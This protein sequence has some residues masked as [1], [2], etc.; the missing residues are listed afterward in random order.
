MCHS[1][2]SPEFRTKYQGSVTSLRPSPSSHPLP[3]T[4]THSQSK[5]DQWKRTVAPMK[6]GDGKCSGR[7]HP[8]FSR[9]SFRDAPETLQRATSRSKNLSR[10]ERK[11]PH[12]KIRRSHHR[13]II[14]PDYPALTRASTKNPD[15]IFKESRRQVGIARLAT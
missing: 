14:Q 7:P 12:Q 6:L 8:A 13:R 11:H 1:V 2:S 15:G 10:G 4:P 3:P 5:A 9:D